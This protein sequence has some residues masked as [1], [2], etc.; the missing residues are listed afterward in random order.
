MYLASPVTGGGIP[1]DRQQQLF[2]LAGLNGKKT[3]GE[4]AKF[5]WDTLSS[6]GHRVI[7]EG[8]LL[9]TPEANLAELSRQAEHF[10]EKRVLILNAL[11]IAL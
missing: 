3:P 7:K 5:A 4:Q 11:G 9:E 1:V 6:Q 10:A 2:M 8:T